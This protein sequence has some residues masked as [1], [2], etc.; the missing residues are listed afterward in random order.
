[1]SLICESTR[2]EKQ[3]R[4]RERT[5]TNTLKDKR[6]ENYYQGPQAFRSLSPITPVSA[7]LF[8]LIFLPPVDTMQ[9][10]AKLSSQSFSALNA[11]IR[12]RP[13]SQGCRRL[14]ILRPIFGEE[15]E[16]FQSLRG[17]RVKAGFI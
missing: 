1:M 11:L 10:N 8:P 3:V 17:R 5:R 4:G 12:T 15:A 13:P 6:K 16:G 14:L 2:G 7:F 9:I